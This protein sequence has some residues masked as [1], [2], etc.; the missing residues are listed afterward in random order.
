MPFAREQL[1]KDIELRLTQLAERIKGFTSS[2]LGDAAKFLEPFA[3]RLLNASYGWQL[4]DPDPG[5]PTTKGIDLVDSVNLVAVQVTV[6]ESSEK[7]AHTAKMVSDGKLDAFTTK[8]VF[9][10]NHVK[11]TKTHGLRLI[12]IPVLI[13]DLMPKDVP[14]LESIVALIKLETASVERTL[15]DQTRLRAHAQPCNLPYRPLGALFMG[16]DGDMAKLREAL[17][18][19]AQRAGIN[20][21]PQVAAAHGL[22]GIGKTRLA[23][24][25]AWQHAG[26]YDALLFADAS[27]PDSLATS[28]AGLSTALVHHLDLPVSAPDDDRRA[29]VI[30]WLK[31]HPRAL[32]ILDNIDDAHAA[33]AVR[34]LLSH[35]PRGSVILTGRIPRWFENVTP[36]ALDVLSVEDSAAFLLQRT[37]QRTPTAGDAPQA[38]LLAEKLDGLA[39][40]LEQ[41]ASWINDRGATFAG[42]LHAWDA[43]HQECLRWWDETQSHVAGGTRPYGKSVFTTWL[44]TVETLTPDARLLLDLCAWFAPEPIPEWIMEDVDTAKLW[45]EMAGGPTGSGGLRPPSANDPRSALPGTPSTPGG[46]VACGV[47][48]NGGETPPLPVPAPDPA[49]SLHALIRSGM[50]TRV[51]IGPAEEPRSRAFLLHRIVQ[52]VTRQR[53]QPAETADALRLLAIGWMAALFRGDV[54]AVANWPQ[55][56]PLVPHARH[57]AALADDDASPHAHVAC[58]PDATLE[59]RATSPALDLA[60]HLYWPLA[61]WTASHGNI[62]TAVDWGRLALARLLP[63]LGPEHPDTLTV[64]NNLANALRDRTPRRARRAGARAGAGASR[65]ARQPEQPCHRATGAGKTHG[66]RDR[67]PR[68]ARRAGARAGAGASRYAR[69]PEQ[70][71][72]CAA[73]AGKKRGGRDRTLCRDSRA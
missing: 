16:R 66:G 59:S 7:I 19:G 44:T 4:A 38:L 26:D 31:A 24:E 56:D 5:N 6:Q 68:R 71:R 67:T 30:A 51:L 49:D 47:G 28:I 17:H 69:Q 22:G 21:Q 15:D 61:L 42:Y 8:A 3:A 70:P 35:I 60:G 63:V 1:I 13:A 55:F 53:Q 27:S 18:S 34:D 65:Y 32:L 2:G 33:G 36:L 43:K 57:C 72:Q 39:L 11:H 50:A 54:D 52:D 46:E 23:C 9:L 48:A 29:A 73:R 58:P 14:V 40:L 20:M 62:H 37:V 12:N 45:R 25:Y 64:R 41:A 10:F